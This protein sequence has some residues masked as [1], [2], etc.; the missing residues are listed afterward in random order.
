MVC[1]NLMGVGCPVVAHAGDLN[2]VVLVRDIHNGER[3]LVEVE[4]NLER[5]NCAIFLFNVL[6]QKTNR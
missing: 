4:A 5:E 3:V 1:T 2:L 6:G